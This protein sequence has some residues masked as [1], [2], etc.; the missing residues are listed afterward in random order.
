MCTSIALLGIA[1]NQKLN[2]FPQVSGNLKLC[3]RTIAFYLTTI[4]T[5]RNVSIG[6]KPSHLPTVALHSLRRNASGPICL[7]QLWPMALAGC[8]WGKDFHLNNQQYSKW[9]A[10]L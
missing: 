4:K 5:W 3:L 7:T 1:M 10:C 9:R 8:G 2:V 6:R